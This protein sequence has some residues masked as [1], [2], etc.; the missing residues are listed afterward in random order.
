MASIL[1]ALSM[2]TTVHRFIYTFVELGDG[3]FY[4]IF[5]VRRLKFSEVKVTQP[6]SHFL[7]SF[8]LNM[9]TPC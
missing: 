9:L 3:Y 7:F 2:P 8:F 4:P 6:C 1:C 5:L